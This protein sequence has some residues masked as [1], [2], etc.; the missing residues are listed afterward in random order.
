MKTTLESL[1]VGEG[2]AS[3]TPAQ[4]ERLQ[5]L[6]LVEQFEGMLLTEMLRDVKAGDEEDGILGL[7]GSTMT[8]M[9][10]GEF[11][12]ALSKSGGLGLRGM[13]EAALLRS[14]ALAGAGASAGTAPVALASGDIA[15]PVAPGAATPAAPPVLPAAA[16]V[17][18]SIDLVAG[19]VRV[20]S[21]YGWRH[22]P[23]TGDAKF[24]RGVD[25]AAAYGSEVRAFGPGVVTSAGERPGYGLT[26]V[27]DHG[28]GRETLYAHLSA[29]AVEPGQAVEAGQ[30]L[31]LSGQSGRATGPHLHF[32]AREFG[33][34][35]DARGVAAA[36][37]GRTADTDVGESDE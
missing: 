11:G 16:P 36:W 3:L 5:V 22:D 31:A 15:A 14:P 24:H 17:D 34:S 35:V 21:P 27:V 23:F 18:G 30:R 12:L 13:L 19:P 9:M 25:L 2:A 33:R 29:L 20:T 1:A 7:G 32:E 6:T 37:N 10:Q 4:A 26:V 8:D 28:G